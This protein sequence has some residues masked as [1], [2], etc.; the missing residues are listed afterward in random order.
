VPPTTGRLSIWQNGSTPGGV[1]VRVN[2]VP[3]GTLS[4][5]FPSAQPLCGQVGT[6]T[7]TVGAGAAM[8]V[9]NWTDGQLQWVAAPTVTANGCTLYGLGVPATAPPAP[10]PPTGGAGTGLTGADSPDLVWISASFTGGGTTPVN[11]KSRVSSS[12][13]GPYC[14]PTSLVMK[15]YRSGTDQVLSI[16]SSCGLSGVGYVCATSGTGTTQPML[17]ICAQDPFLTPANEITRAVFD[18]RGSPGSAAVWLASA[19]ISVEVFYCSSVTT[20]RPPANFGKGSCR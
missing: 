10:P 11:V 15:N 19:G 12:M 4:Q 18:T 20:Y 2:G 1:A 13:K 16:A 8:L 5:Y 7:V 9:A 17:P 14:Q 3:A 6:L